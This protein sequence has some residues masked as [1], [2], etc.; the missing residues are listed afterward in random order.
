MLNMQESNVQKFQVI[1]NSMTKS[2]LENPKL[3]SVS[4]I[5]RIAKGSGTT[6]GDVRL[7]IKQYSQMRGMMKKMKGGNLKKMMKQLGIKDLDALEKSM[8][9]GL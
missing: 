8:G 7:L 4:R 9:G 5:Q 3:L 1:M 6:E 2:E